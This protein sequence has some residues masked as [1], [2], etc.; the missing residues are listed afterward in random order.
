MGTLERNETLSHHLGAGGHLTIKAISGALRVRGIEGEDV[1]VTIS[2]RI[3]AADQASAERALESGRVTLDRGPGYLEIETPE[4]RLASGL[5][6]LF[7]GAR[8]SADVSVDVPWGARVVI[9]TMSGSIDAAN[10]V[11][12][13]KYRTVSG[14]IRLWSLG[15][16]V[17]AGSISGGITLD[18]A[19]TLRLRANTISGGI[20]ARAAVFASLN[21]STTSGSMKVIAAL[22][23]AGDH[24]AES[25]SGGLDFT[26]LSGVSAEL[27]TVSGSIKS[28]LDHRVEGSRGNWRAFVGDGRAHLRFNSTSGSLRLLAPRPSDGPTSAPAAGTQPAAGGTNPAAPAGPA[29]TDAAA[30]P[31]G[32]ATDTG[33]AT[34]MGSPAPAGEAT[35]TGATNASAAGV[36]A[37]NGEPAPGPETA[38]VDGSEETWNPEENPADSAA[39]SG[40]GTD[41][42]ELA[43][44]L[45]LERGEIGVD[46]AAA[47][48]ERTRGRANVR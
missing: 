48:L 34:E 31:M 24:K 44:L 20:R 46:E 25:I 4:R 10:L 9:E 3:R 11:G 14:D 35:G 22:D 28:E 7:A 38:V 12:E 26:P 17:E 32:T 19:S 45:A 36:V 6:W 15:G 29:S 18:G 33:P 39:Q 21:L 5:A 30:T 8:V 43:V 23:P 13:Q 47:R 2:Y 41:E 37:A 40:P 16:L 27:R 1:H 42:D